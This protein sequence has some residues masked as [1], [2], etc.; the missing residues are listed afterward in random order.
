MVTYIQLKEKQLKRYDIID[1]T[2]NSIQASGGLKF[3]KVNSSENLLASIRWISSLFNPFPAILSILKVSETYLKRSYP[4]WGLSPP[5]PPPRDF[6]SSHITQYYTKGTQLIRL[7]NQILYL[8]I[9][10][11]LSS[12]QQPILK[13]K[14]IHY[15][16][17][18]KNICYFIEQDKT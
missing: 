13:L 14:S 18:S 2:C 3:I 8:L 6:A 10:F 5:P 11:N 4:V 7:N 16:H 1:L 12:T 17:Y 9:H 15:L